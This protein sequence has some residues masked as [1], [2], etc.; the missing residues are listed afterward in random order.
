MRTAHHVVVDARSGSWE[1]YRLNGAEVGRDAPVTATFAWSDPKRDIAILE[2][3][4]RDPRRN[5]AVSVVTLGRGRFDA[6]LDCI[7]IG[8]PRFASDQG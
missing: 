7:A 6:R 4:P 5:D 2:I 8:L 3:D 1:A